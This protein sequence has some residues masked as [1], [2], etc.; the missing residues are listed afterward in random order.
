MAEETAPTP[1]PSRTGGSPSATPREKKSRAPET[2]V[3]RSK[4]PA[5]PER[6]APAPSAP[7]KTTL[8]SS[9]SGGGTADRTTAGQILSLVNEERAQAGCPALKASAALDRAAQKYS[10]TMASDGELSHTGPDG[11][12]VADRVGREGYAWSAVG[13]NIAVGQQDARAVMDSWMNSE[14][15]RANILNCSFEELGVG[16]RHSGGPWWTQ[17]FATGR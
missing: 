11:S 7:R 5:T 8:R 16:V 13:E 6:E 15:H 3:T 2:P 4:A 17:V 12:T 10:E 1:S 9:G 14:G